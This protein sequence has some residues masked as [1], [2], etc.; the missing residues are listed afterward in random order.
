MRRHAILDDSL[1][2]VNTTALRQRT[3]RLFVRHAKDQPAVAQADVEFAD[4]GK[5][6]LLQPA[7]A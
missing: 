7:A 3:T 2:L 5:A 4:G 1:A 6:Q